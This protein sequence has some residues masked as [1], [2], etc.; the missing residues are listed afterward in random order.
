MRLLA[1]LA[2]VAFLQDK[3][4]GEQF[5]KFKVGT[6][7]TLTQK[8]NDK[9]ST[10]EL[11]VL[12][13]DG[14]K[15]HIESKEDKGEG[16]VR[17]QTLVWYCEDEA[18]LWGELAKDGTLRPQIRYYKVGSK[19]GDTWDANAGKGG[20]PN[21]KATHM[22]TAEVKVPAGTYKDALHVQIT[23]DR[24]TINMYWAPGVGIVKMDGAMGEDTMLIELKE[25]KEG[26]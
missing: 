11:K 19:K 21:A 14:G 25:F 13:E 3:D 1:A 10:I 18:L 5:Y 24:G 8:E 20:P 22:G 23:M 7:W 17:E 12:K 15:V 6:S 26:K 16:R 2:L 9:Q 4:T